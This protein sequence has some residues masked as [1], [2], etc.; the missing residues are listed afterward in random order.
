MEWMSPLLYRATD[1]DELF[2][3][4]RCLVL[5]LPQGEASLSHAL[6][7]MLFDPM[8]DRRR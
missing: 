7:P 1:L 2:Q 4:M 8:L 5:P 6:R 3:L